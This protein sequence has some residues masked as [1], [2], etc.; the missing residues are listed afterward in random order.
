MSAARSGSKSAPTSRV[1][2]RRQRAELDTYRRKRAFE[3]TPEPSGEPGHRPT[4]PPRAQDLWDELP[5]GRRF[6]VQLHRARALHYDFRLEG[7]GVL[8]SWA[9][10]KGPSL[11]PRV[12]RLA[13]HVEDHP[14]EYGSFEGVIPSGYGA[15]QV[16]LWDLGEVRWPKGK[17][18]AL[19]KGHLTFELVGHRLK[20]GFS[21]VR[22]EHPREAEADEWLLMKSKDE[23]ATSSVES[24][25][26]RSVATGRTLDEIQTGEAPRA[27]EASALSTALGAAP[28]SPLPQSLSP[29]LATL[30]REPFSGSDWLFELKYDGVRALLRRQGEQIRVLTR[31]GRDRTDTYPEL[32][33]LSGHL[34]E[35]QCLLDGEIVSLDR[36]GAP[37]FAQLQKRMQLGG[38][39]ARHAAERGPIV[40][41]AFDL[42]FAAGHDLRHL[43]L[44]LRKRALREVLTD[45]AVARYA[46][47]VAAAGERFYDTVKARNLEGVIGKRADSPYEAGVRSRNWLKI[48]FRPTQDCVICGYLLGQGRRST[49]GA[50]ILG[51]Y[52]GGAL[53]EA[54][55]VGTGFSDQQL[56]RLRGE[57]DRRQRP[58]SPL[59]DGGSLLQKAV[60]AEPEL[61]CEV[62][63]AGWTAAGVLRQPS[64]RT[65][66]PDV[67]VSACIREQPQAAAEVSGES[68]QGSRRGAA[69]HGRGSSQ[70]TRDPELAG[71]MEKLGQLPDR[72]G[73]LRV[74]RREVTLSRLDKLL[75]PQAKIT[76]RD[77]IAYH[78]QMAPVLL[79]HLRDRAVVLHV[80]PDGAGGKAFWRRSL[81]ASA[82]D[83]IPTWTAS[84]GE[85]TVCPLFKEAA[86]L[87][88]AANAGA[89]EI[90]PWHSRKDRPLQP[91]WAVFDLDP[92]PGAGLSE[93]LEVAGL[94]RAGLEHLE[95]AGIPKTTGQSGL[96]IYVPLRRGP[97]EERVRDWVGEIAHQVALV[98]PKLVTEEWAVRRRQARV[99]ID[100]TQNVVGKTLASVY[101]PRASAWAGVSTPLE[102]D[103]LEDLTRER[104]TLTNVPQRVAERGDLFSEVLNGRQRLPAIGRSAQASS[105]SRRK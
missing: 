17:G 72:G 80:F 12:R 94:V 87:V 92:G 54:G 71:T 22:M 25:E 75:W 65:M 60:W 13:V 58:T 16:M 61:V 98:A 10:P 79:P 35:D 62:E 45:S 76:K 1:N 38:E 85:P 42:L 67:P 101:S 59:A 33:A 7:R 23:W 31:S 27:G 78:L 64:F 19:A 18:R 70:T 32:Q 46:D 11:N 102:W 8:L 9:V 103:E 66:R 26:P 55:R 15:G 50:L 90:H 4:A 6:C 37:S 68:S 47:D 73:V 44:R 56:S 5:N 91:D 29:M 43:P 3:H 81:P 93:V 34:S 21:L 89:L 2:G 100:Y 105:A 24:G 96:H 53:V 30:V 88:W 84:P 52:S 57:L 28:R 104:F 20:G 86:A 41:M 77:L 49:I 69:G 82:P 48:K 99:R 83:W 97:A 14:V 74:G 40:F 51:V 36:E 63:H 95:L 39:A